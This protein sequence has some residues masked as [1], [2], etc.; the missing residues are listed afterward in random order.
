MG[1]GGVM[2]MYMYVWSGN[3]YVNGPGNGMLFGL[4]HEKV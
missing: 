3:G 2:V 4:T 1:Q